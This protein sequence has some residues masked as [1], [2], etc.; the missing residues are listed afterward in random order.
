MLNLEGSLTFQNLR[1]PLIDTPFC[2]L[3]PR[4]EG[5]LLSLELLDLLLE[6]L[7]FNHQQLIV[8]HY[9]LDPQG[10]GIKLFSK[11]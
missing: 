5:L 10:E 6:L 1:Q 7:V 2:G 4:V 11:D 9:L 3:H 8:P